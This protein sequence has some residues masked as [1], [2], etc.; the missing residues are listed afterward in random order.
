MAATVPFTATLHNVKVP[1]TP[2]TS[3]QKHNGYCGVL[4]GLPFS[5]TCSLV[6]LSTIVKFIV[7][8]STTMF[9]TSVAYPGAVDHC[10]DCY[11][12]S[13]W[14]LPPFQDVIHFL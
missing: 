1:F 8:D 5:C 3:E 11:W 12:L 9:C 6:P 10:P 4:I 2:I 7:K 13:L 14:V